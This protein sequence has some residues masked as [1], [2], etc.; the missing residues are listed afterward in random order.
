MVDCAPGWE[1][2]G[3]DEN[4]CGGECIGNDHDDLCMFEDSVYIFSQRLF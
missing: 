4:G 2:V 1:L 3:Q